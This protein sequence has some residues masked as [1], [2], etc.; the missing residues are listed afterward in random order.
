MPADAVQRWEAGEL[1]K[2]VEKPQLVGRSKSQLRIVWRGLT[3]EDDATVL[4]PLY[5]EVQRF[6]PFYGPPIDQPQFADWFADTRDHPVEQR[7]RYNA[8]FRW[9]ALV[10]SLV[11]NGLIE[12]RHQLH[13]NTHYRF[14][15]AFVHSN[16]AAHELLAPRSFVAWS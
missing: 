7:Q 13:L 14:L 6:D 12:T 16:H 4:H 10:D 15:S 1:P 2:A 9:G 3:S 11:L 5:F 8:F